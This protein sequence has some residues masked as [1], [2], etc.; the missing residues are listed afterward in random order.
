[1]L[2]TDI[3]G[4][5]YT[6]MRKHSTNS[7]PKTPGSQIVDFY[8]FWHGYL[9]LKGAGCLIRILAP[10]CKSLQIYP[11]ELGEGQTITLD[12]RDI[13]A[14]CWLHHAL[15]EPFEETG[16]LKAMSSVIND[17]SVVWDVGANCGKVSYHLAKESP[18]KQVVFFEP[19][20]A[21]YAISLSATAPFSRVSGMNVALS[22][23]NGYA[24]L[25]IPKS[26]STIAG[27]GIAEGASRVETCIIECRT[28]DSLVSAG[29]VP[30]PTVIK[31]DT[32]GH[33]LSVLGGLR[34]VIATYK[35]AIFLEHLSLS[36][37]ELRGVASD[38]YEIF[39]VSNAD[40]SLTKGLDRLRGHNTA[41]IPI[42]S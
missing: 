22:N 31:I 39:S 41:F 6:H 21:M 19:I 4:L 5:I 29:T 37:A 20:A 10:I 42:D 24:E 2:A 8:R 26:N 17:E 35:P 14:F 3:V 33:E 40:G 9:K 23:L 11:L 15:G 34:D 13:S 36:D 7:H 12:F 18:A 16:L 32:E 38:D 27:I 28:G 25:L 1:M 30:P